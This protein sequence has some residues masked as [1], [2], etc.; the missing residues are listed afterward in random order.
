MELFLH[1]E[2]FLGM[3]TEGNFSIITGTTKYDVFF[4]S[5]DIPFVYHPTEEQAIEF[6]HQD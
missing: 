3:N 5:I 6:I 2:K 4:T 1:F